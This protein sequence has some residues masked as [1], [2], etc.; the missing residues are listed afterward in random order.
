MQIYDRII[1]MKEAKQASIAT[2]EAEMAAYDGRIEAY[3]KNAS[4]F[5]KF[6]EGSIKRVLAKLMSTYEEEEYV[7]MQV[8]YNFTRYFEI[9]G[10]YIQQY[11]NKP[12]IV[13]AKSNA[14]ESYDDDSDNSLISLLMGGKAIILADIYYEGCSIYFYSSCGQDLDFHGDIRVS[15]VRDFIDMVIEYR[16]NNGLENID[17]VTLEA[18]LADFLKKNGE[19]LD[20]YKNNKTSG[21]GQRVSLGE[22]QKKLAKTMEQKI[23]E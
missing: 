16:M 4:K 6:D 8:T 17:E 19:T 15:Y 14:S 11:I 1:K 3:A 9:H 20:E 18:L 12:L 2:F 13:V 5:S 7:P 21:T 22:S 10:G 23:Q